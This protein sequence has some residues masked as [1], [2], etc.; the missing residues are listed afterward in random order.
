MAG[1]RSRAWS[2]LP[3]NPVWQFALSVLL[4]A[5]LVGAGS[6][7]FFRSA[8]TSQAI[9]QARVVAATIARTAI[10][11]SL[12]NSIVA[13]NRQAIASLD[14]VVR[15]YV[16]RGDVVRV[17][18]WTPAGRIVYSDEHRLIG[19]VYPL[20]DEDLETIR[21]G[22]A[23]ADISDLNKA[24]NRYERQF[25]KL[26][27]VY[28][29]VTTPNE[30]PLLFETYQRYSSVSASGYSLWLAFLPVL[31]GALALLAVVQLSLA[32]SLARRLRGGQQERERLLLRAIQASNT[33]RRRI[34]AD[35]HDTVV[36][37]L[38]GISLSLG[39]AASQA[40]EGE[41][42]S[43]LER[44]AAATRQ[45]IRRLRSLLV[46]IYPP[47]LQAEGLSAALSDLLEPLAEHQVET[48]LDVRDSVHLSP[49]GEQLVFRCAQ[50]AL[51]NVAAHSGARNVTVTLS[52]NG[53]ETVRLTVE[54][55]GKG[56]TP[57]DVA[58]KQ[59]SGHLGMTLLAD[60]AADFGAQL[61]VDSEPGRG[62]RVVLE[63][64]GA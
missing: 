59:A 16:V 6:A 50:E 1:K 27:Q 33:E 17:K 8:G 25:G 63:V 24:E 10:E 26:L 4:A 14:R 39:A 2:V 46:D 47:N 48:S 21:T 13:G 51:R 20:G 35:L 38:A 29:R 52:E 11:P 62:T 23:S 64:P 53:G 15:R 42:R 22:R 40:G 28:L 19:S 12:D 34:A 44:G 41:T 30:Q 18:L 57:A 7:Y 9:K 43:L 32:W 54:D 49:A 31:L 37:D 3:R 5:V 61:K 55:D 56:F 58:A 36:Q 60:A 45:S